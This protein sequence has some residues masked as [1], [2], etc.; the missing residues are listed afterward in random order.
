MGNNRIHCVSVTGCVCVFVGKHDKTREYFK[1]QFMSGRNGSLN[2]IKELIYK[3][4][5]DSQTGRTSL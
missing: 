5:T 1:Q 4:E 2:D 3:A